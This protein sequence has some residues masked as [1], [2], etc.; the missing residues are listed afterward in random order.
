MIPL[1]VIAA[2]VAIIIIIKKMFD[3]SEN[4]GSS[5]SHYT[6]SG[7]TSHS[8]PPVSNNKHTAKPSLSSYDIDHAQY[9]LKQLNESA[10]IVNHT[11][12]PKTYFGRLNFLFDTLMEMTKYEKS[13]I[14]KGSS[15]T[16]NLNKLKNDLESSVNAFID[17][18]Y[19]AQII[20]T[21]SLKTEQGK[22]NS[23]NK[24]FDSMFAA[25]ECANT[26]WTGD[27]VKVHY[28]GE[29]FTSGNMAYLNSLHEECKQTYN[30]E[31]DMDT[32]IKNLIPKTEKPK[33]IFDKAKEKELLAEYSKYKN[34]VDSSNT[35]YSALPLI[36]FYY[37]YRT[38]D[39]KYLNLCMEYCNI[40]ISLLHTSGMK[41]FLSDGICIPAFKKL[42][43]IYDKKKEYEKALAII[44][45]A[46]KFDRE[47]E[48]YEKKKASILKK[49][50]K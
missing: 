1:I 37:K 8:Y 19:E 20:K 9:L 16:Q 17:R 27:S 15:P 46:V 42:V 12:N 35:Y 21:C 29:L 39:D 49:M 2:I 41:K 23:L 45:E 48:Y 6:S 36:D 40:C 31:G 33:L 10:N 50:S 18:A 28:V 25:F 47:V 34:D 32:A 26:F 24:F 14:Y 30:L 43:I 22:I 7:N 5:S 38:L 11:T 3:T 4:T 13:G 44:D